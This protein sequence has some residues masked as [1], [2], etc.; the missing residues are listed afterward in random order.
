MLIFPAI[1]IYDGSCVRL[2]KGEVKKKTI[3]NSSPLNQAVFFEKCGFKNLHIVDLNFAIKGKSK[4]QKII[5]TI[6]KKTKLSLQLGGGIRSYKD[7]SYWLNLGIDSIVIGTMFYEKNNDFERCV[8]SYP[9]KISFA[10]DLRANYLAIRGWKKQT[11]ISADQ[12]VSQINKFNLKSVIY[13]DIQRDGT[14]QG[15]NFKNLKKYSFKI[16]APLIASGGI[17][18][19]E[20]IYNLKK[21]KKLRGVIVGRSI[22]DGSI[23]LS[24]LIKLKKNA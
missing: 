18:S 12:L 4:N 5:E 19:I 16:N 17:G 22:Y 1:D 15:P 9:K 21:I 20:D 10:M 23:N 6:K 8:S 24:D 7:A 3:Y 11:K 2:L 14:K 13:T